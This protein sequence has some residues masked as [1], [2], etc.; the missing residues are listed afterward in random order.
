MRRLLGVLELL[1]YLD[2]RPA[3]ALAHV[4]SRETG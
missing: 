3:L 1:D 2:I 4:P